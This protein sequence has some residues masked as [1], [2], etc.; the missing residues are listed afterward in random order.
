[1]CS[2][3]S[4]YR[5]VNYCWGMVLLR[6]GIGVQGAPA[7]A[8]FLIARSSLL[9]AS[10]SIQSLLSDSD[11]FSSPQRVVGVRWG[12]PLVDLLLWFDRQNNGLPKMSTF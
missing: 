7:F 6:P 9:C 10:G 3:L 11:C 8:V 2:S 1:M 4:S 5:I 12:M